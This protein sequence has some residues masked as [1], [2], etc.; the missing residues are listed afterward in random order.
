MIRGGFLSIE[1]R[2]KLTQIVRRPGEDHGVARRANAILLL[3]DGKS[4]EEIAEFLYLDDDTVR[5]WYKRYEHG[6][7][8]ELET[9]DGLIGQITH[10]L[11]ELRR[12]IQIGPKRRQHA[13]VTLFRL[14]Q[15]VRRLIGDVGQIK[16]RYQIRYK[17]R[18][19]GL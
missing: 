6:G 17:I 8:D 10:G 7:F 5:G 14:G 2:A 11:P 16:Q 15:E 3:D 1:E 19:S 9:F 12:L 4:C 18:V 13:G